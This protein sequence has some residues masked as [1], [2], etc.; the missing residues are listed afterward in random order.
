MSA[1]LS[2]NAQAIMLLTAPLLVGG[3]RRRGRVRA[4]R[5]SAQPTDRPRPLSAAE[6]RDFAQRLRTIAR[7]PADLLGKHSTETLRASGSNLDGER[8]QRLLGRGFLLAQAVERWRSCALWVITRADPDYP[9][10]LKTRLGGNTPPVLYGCGDRSILY[11]GGL[12]VVG[13]RKV[14]EDLIHYAER[15]GRLSAEADKT[16]VSGG[17]RGTD[18]AA[19]RGALEAG[20]RSVGVLA[21]GLERAALN[22]ENRNVLMEGRLVLVC[23]YDPTARFLVGHAMQRNKLIYA[24]SDAALVVNSD[25]G[26]GGTW[27]GATEQLNKLR[28]VPVYVRATGERSEGLEGL[29]DHGARSWPNPKTPEELHRILRDGPRTAGIPALPSGKTAGQYDLGLVEAWKVREKSDTDWGAVAGASP[30]ART[31]D[32]LLL[33]VSGDMSRRELLAALQLRNLGHLR[34]RYLKPSLQEGWIEMTIPEKP[35]SRNQ[36]FRLTPAGR[37]R[38]ERIAVREPEDSKT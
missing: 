25:L 10:Q 17:A 21:N 31:A 16:I 19:M 34:E 2:P 22:R 14:N 5:K 35:S 15:V 7:E 36:R 30:E 29:R 37:D 26:R 38:L 27:S 32:R 33:A 18:Q 1:D 13:S 6:Y 12:S 8:I 24:L 23:P 11:G 9:Q 28:F 4:G 3:R 20:G